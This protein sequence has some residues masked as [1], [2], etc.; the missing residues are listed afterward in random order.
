VLQVVRSNHDFIDRRQHHH[1][2]PQQG[3][4]AGRKKFRQPIVGRKTFL[5]IA[6]PY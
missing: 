5:P 2:A 1:V 4:S 3:E 6:L